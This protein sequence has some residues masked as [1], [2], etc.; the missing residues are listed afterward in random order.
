MAPVPA[1]RF[2]S[3]VQVP[4]D[5]DWSPIAKWLPVPPVRAL[6]AM[7]LRTLAL[8]GVL[9]PRR[10]A[11]ELAAPLAV[12][13]TSTL[14]WSIATVLPPNAKSKMPR[15]GCA[16]AG[17]GAITTKLLL[18][19][20]LA[21]LVELPANWMPMMGPVE[22]ALACR[23][24]IR[25]PV[26]VPLRTSPNTAPAVAVVTPV[27]SRPDTRLP[28]NTLVPTPATTLM[29]DTA[30]E[31]VRP[32]IVLPLNSL[33]P[34][35][36]LTTM[37]N[38]PV[39]RDAVCEIVLPTT[40]TLSVPEPMNT[41]ACRK[42]IRV[43]FSIRRFELVT[44]PAAAIG[45][46]RLNGG[47]PATSVRSRN[48]LPVISMS[49]LPVIA[50]APTW[51]MVEPLLLSTVVLRRRL[52]EA[53]FNHRIA[54]PAPVSRSRRL[55][56]PA[57]RP[58]I[59]MRSAPLTLIRPLPVALAPTTVRAPDGTMVTLYAPPS[60]TSGLSATAPVSPARSVVMVAVTLPVS[61]PLL[62]ASNRPPALVSEVIVSAVPTFTVAGN[63]AT[64]V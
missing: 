52:D 16:D 17:S 31:L 1:N 15:T 62:S 63:G 2:P 55:L 23:S 28:R 19:T 34:D 30:A 18:I 22:V 12:P 56:P 46:T 32:L 45:P 8:V 35:M 41:P 26:N 25:L 5:S 47:S 40:R 21:G 3:E 33:L 10:M 53:S 14:L 11:C 9:L 4:V 58:S 20:R 7:L 6:K 36:L 61:T 60:C 64:T 43:L 51:I 57:A 48:V 42:L 29:P 27:E 38:S 24:S 13:P 59:V 50:T 44:G 54:P 39:A 37:P 49:S